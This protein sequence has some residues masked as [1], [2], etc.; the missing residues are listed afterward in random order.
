MGFGE[1]GRTSG[2][3]KVIRESVQVAQTVLE[4]M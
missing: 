4:R 1:A 3:L 2:I